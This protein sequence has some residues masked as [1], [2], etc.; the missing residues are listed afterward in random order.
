MTGRVR[1]LFRAERGSAPAEFVMVAALLTVLTL[2]VMQLAL[3]LHIRNTVLDAASEGA[4]YASLADNELSD[5]ARRTQELITTAIGPGYAGDVTVTSQTHLGHPAAVVTVRAPL[6][7]IGL[8]GI[9]HGL[10]VSGH[11]ALETLE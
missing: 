5:G 1:A 6:P 4:R 2:S 10:E 9:S 7:L 11:A 3:A 8:I